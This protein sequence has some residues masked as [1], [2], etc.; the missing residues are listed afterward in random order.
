MNV[1][2]IGQ[3]LTEGVLPVELL[4]NVKMITESNDSFTV[5]R[6]LEPRKAQSLP[7]SIVE[8]L[9]GDCIGRRATGLMQIWTGKSNRSV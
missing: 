8:P 1:V 9:L 5:K 3:Q 6:H 4:P 7:L 2:L